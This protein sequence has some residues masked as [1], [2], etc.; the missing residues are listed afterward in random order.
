[1]S[2]ILVWKRAGVSFTVTNHTTLFTS[3]A[4]DHLAQQD[5]KKN[6]VHLHTTPGLVHTGSEKQKPTR[7][8]GFLRWVFLSFLKFI[9]RT[10]VRFTGTSV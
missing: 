4:F 7:A 8:S 2:K 1:M 3:L 6:F 5:D 10:I 9:A